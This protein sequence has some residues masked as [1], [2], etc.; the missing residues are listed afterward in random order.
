[1]AK[2][3]LALN[4]LKC[5]GQFNEELALP[6]LDCSLPRGNS[7]VGLDRITEKEQA[8]LGSIHPGYNDLVQTRNE[9]VRLYRAAVGNPVTLASLRADI[10]DCR[11]SAYQSLNRVLLAQLNEKRAQRLG[12]GEGRKARGS[13]REPTSPSRASLAWTHFITRLTL[14]R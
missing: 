14:M 11:T 10:D 12:S 1:M 8:L 5:V 6:N 7:L 4:L 3:R 2:L 9:L 13:R